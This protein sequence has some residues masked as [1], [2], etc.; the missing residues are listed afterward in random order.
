MT[1]HAPAL[2]SPW[3]LLITSGL[4]G[5]VAV[6]GTH[7][8]VANSGKIGEYN[9]ST[10][11]AIITAVVTWMIF[12]AIL[13]FAKAALR[14]PGDSRVDTMQATTYNKSVVTISYNKYNIK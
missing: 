14:R 10:G 9:A 6:L 4:R 7:L 1:I 8:F 11:T 13:R 3:R 2:A 5:A 12:E